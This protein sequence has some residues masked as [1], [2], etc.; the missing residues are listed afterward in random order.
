MLLRTFWRMMA[1]TMEDTKRS[2]SNCKNLWGPHRFPLLRCCWTLQTFL[3]KSY[4]S[5]RCNINDS[6]ERSVLIWCNLRSVEPNG[7]RWMVF[8]KKSIMTIRSGKRRWYETSLMFRPKS[9]CL[10]HLRLLRETYVCFW[11]APSERLILYAKVAP[12]LLLPLPPPHPKYGSKLTP[13]RVHPSSSC[14]STRLVNSFICLP[15][16]LGRTS[17]VLISANSNPRYYLRH[18][19]DLR[20]PHAGGWRTG[21]GTDSTPPY[22]TGVTVGDRVLSCSISF[23]LFHRAGLSI[24]TRLD[25][26]VQRRMCIYGLG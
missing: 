26:R 22:T 19:K 8:D 14:W 11:P 20:T 5:R 3:T 17:P 15:T 21:G 12:L 10:F 7:E 23:L 24:Q 18:P 6:V 13:A 9:G 25:H 1:G 2:I 4:R 16:L